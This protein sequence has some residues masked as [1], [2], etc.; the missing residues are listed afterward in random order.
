MPK[1][2]RITASRA[3]DNAKSRLL[4][5]IIGDRTASTP[6]V[7]HYAQVINSSDPK[8]A[9]RLQVRIPL[10]DDGL[11]TDSN[12]QLQD[13]I[14]D[15]LLPWAISSHGR[16]VDTPENDTV[17]LVALFDPNNPRAGRLWITAVPELSSTDI[18]DASRLTD[19]LDANTWENA[20]GALGIGFDSSPSLRGR[21]PFVSQTRQINY[22][23]GLRGK[24]KNSLLFDQATT[25][26]VQNE[27]DSQN[28]SKIVL[29]DQM[30]MNA[31]SFSMIANQSTTKQVPVF[32]K[33]L[34]DYMT[35][36][37]SIIDQIIIVLNTMPSLW[38]GSVPNV[39]NPQMA[40]VQAQWQ[41][42]KAQFAN[43]KQP[44]IGSSQYITIT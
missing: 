40:T 7:F 20:E 11:Y 36:H 3:E 14:G 33:P 19:E 30:N 4:D 37:Q 38:M 41:S 23:V 5:T 25:T 24:D 32:A 16:E 43:L 44:G 18:F 17:V 42:V 27:N 2:N 10:I 34:F 39:P 22:K 21:P 31:S 9:N 1:T 6:R 8:N 28:E 35:Q 29:T 15:S 13:G 26:L 12:A